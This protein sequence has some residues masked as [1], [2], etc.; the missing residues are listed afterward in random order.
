MTLKELK[1]KYPDK[2]F[3]H[4]EIHKIYEEPFK[5]LGYVLYGTDIHNGTEFIVIGDL[6]KAK[7]F[8]KN[9]QQAIEYVE[10]NP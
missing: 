1:Q 9:L 10:G 7:Q 8:S 6:N 3:G 4:I 5:D 2:E